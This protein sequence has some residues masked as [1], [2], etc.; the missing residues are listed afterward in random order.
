MI[1]R[2][3]EL[4]VIRDCVDADRSRLIVVYRRRPFAEH[5][6]AFFRNAAGTGG[7]VD[8]RFNWSSP[9]NI[10]EDGDERV[11]CFQKY[12]TPDATPTKVAF[13]DD[14]ARLY[15]I[16]TKDFKTWTK[17]ELI[18]VKG[19]NVSEAEM[20]RMIDAYLVKGTDGLWW[21]FYK[22][23]QDKSGR[24]SEKARMGCEGCREVRHVLPRFGSA[25]GDRWR[26]LQKLFHRYCVVQRPEGMDVARQGMQLVE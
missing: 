21:C 10:V 16:R 8:K 6:P 12:P 17:P 22:Q 19:P 3:K 26:L 20:W 2:K 7:G 24:F 15:T 23:Q 9:G 13:A 5:R 4:G 25:E 1:G 18:M 11:P 14:T